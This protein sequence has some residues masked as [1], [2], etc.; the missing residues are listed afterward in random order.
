MLTLEIKA[1][2]GWLQGIAAKAFDTRTILKLIGI[3]VLSFIDRQF[4]TAGT[5]GGSPWQPLRPSTLALRMRGG[6]QPLRDNGAYSQS[7]TS[8]IQSDSAV[9]VGSTS[10]IG[11]FHEYGTSPYVITARKKI[12]AAQMR[13]GGWMFFGK[14]VHHPG[15]PIRAVFPTNGPMERIITE[16]VDNYVEN[17]LGGS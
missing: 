11:P 3:R 6:N 15:L 17:S 7:F 14:T 1:P 16:E 9:W 10:K 5:E 13:A 4:Q 12:L 8:Q 2:D